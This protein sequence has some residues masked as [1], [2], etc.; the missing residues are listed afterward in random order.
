[1]KTRT[2]VIALAVAIAV[3]GA[4][5]AAGPSVRAADKTPEALIEHARAVTLAP[6][7]SS[8]EITGALVEVLDA[9]LLILPAADYAEDFK[10]RIGTVR[11]MLA[12]GILFSDKERQYLGFAYKLVSGGAAW[13]VPAE[14]TDEARMEKSIELAKK[15]CVGL[16]DSALA[17][18]K[19]G[20]NERSV[21]DLVAYVLL[22]VTPMEA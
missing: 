15:L 19:A 6:H 10:A 17:E 18:L 3:L 11:K 2:T 16:L 4:L 12:E 22:V 9:S 13:K 7:F 20:R 1:M 5:P 8:E 21:R 14:L